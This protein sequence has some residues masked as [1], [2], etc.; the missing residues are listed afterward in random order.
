MGRVFAKPSR[1][2][3]FTQSRGGRGRRGIWGL[4]VLLILKTLVGVSCAPLRQSEEIRFEIRGPGAAKAPLPALMVFGGFEHAA[5]TLDLLPRRAD[6]ITASFDYPFR[7]T[8]RFSF[9][10]SW[11]ELPQ[12][13]EAM[14]QTQAGIAR[15]KEVLAQDPRVDHRRIGIVGSSFGAPIAIE[16]AARDP[17]IRYLVIVHGFAD[18]KGELRFRL[19]QLLRE[20]WGSAAPFLAW[21]TAQITLSILRPPHPEEG[22]SRLRPHQRVLIFEARNDEFISPSSKKALRLA[23]RKSPAKVMWVSTEG[24]HVLPGAGSRIAEISSQ[25]IDWIGQHSE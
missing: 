2:A 16:A 24:G 1:M 9:P 6:V 11:V 14:R 21:I 4:G 17:S 22:L 20:R 23:A 7:G 5:Q 13:R 8:R 10:R 3:F 18:L 12:L 19:E 25:I 15:L